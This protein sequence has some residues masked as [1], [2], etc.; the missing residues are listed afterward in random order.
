MLPLHGG[1]CLEKSVI[2]SPRS[3]STSKFT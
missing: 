1:Q 3:C 2:T